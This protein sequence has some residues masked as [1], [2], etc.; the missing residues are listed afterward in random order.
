MSSRCVADIA[1][2]D[3]VICGGP[4]VTLNAAAPET[5]LA[6]TKI[7]VPEDWIAFKTKFTLPITVKWT[8]L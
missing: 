6:G 5:A 1:L 8:G 2:L 4:L 3:H 7:A